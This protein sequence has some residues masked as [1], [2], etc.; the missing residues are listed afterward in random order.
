[1]TMGRNFVISLLKRRARERK[2]QEKERSEKLG[3]WR[4]TEGGV[5][6]P[7]SADRALGQSLAGCWRNLACPPSLSPVTSIA[8]DN[9]E[10]GVTMGGAD[11]LNP[12][13]SI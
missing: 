5:D 6:N 4:E 9:L 8:C 1:M 13:P 3:R 12:H 10:Q 11:F 2:N 7:R